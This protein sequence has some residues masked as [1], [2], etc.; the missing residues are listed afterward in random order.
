MW[1]FSNM[2]TTKTRWQQKWLVNSLIRF[3]TK[4]MEVIQECLIFF[5]TFPLWWFGDFFPY[6]PFPGRF[7]VRVFYRGEIC[8]LLG[9]L[10]SVHFPPTFHTLFI[11]SPLLFLSL[12]PPHACTHTHTRPDTQSP[13]DISFSSLSS[14]VFPMRQPSQK[15]HK[16]TLC[17]W[18]VN[19]T[20]AVT[21]TVFSPR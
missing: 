12:F 9:L 14:L 10:S 19:T 17:S 8:F 5:F 16:N 1:Q 21:V 4:L 15:C 6:E 3:M 18:Y 20:K 2:F 11:F 7:I 13:F